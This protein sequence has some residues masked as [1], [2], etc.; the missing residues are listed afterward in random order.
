MNDE[1]RNHI[2]PITGMGNDWTVF[3]YFMEQRFESSIAEEYVLPVSIV[4][5]VYNR[6]EK[7]AKTIAA[8][9]HQTYPN[10]LMEIIIADDGSSDNPQELCETFKSFFKMSYIYQEDRGYRLSEIRNKGV[11]AAIH[12]Q[13]IILDCDMLPL[14]NLVESYMKYA[15]IS[16]KAVLIGGRR[17]VNTDNVSWEEIIDD[18]TSVSTLPSLDSGTGKIPEKGKPPSEDWRYKIYRSTNQL[19]NSKYPF[20]AFCG[21][22][23]CFHKSLI[24]DVGGFDEDFTA[25]GAEDTE[26]GFRVY[27]QG[28]W[29]IPV[30]GAEALHQEP[31]EGSNETDRDAG[32]AITQPLLIEKCPAFYR[33]MEKDRIYEVPKVSIYIPAYN[34][35]KFIVEAINSALNQTYTDIEIVVVNDGSIDSTGELLDSIYSSNRR[36]R[37]IHQKNGGISSATNTAINAC[38]GEY[39]LQLDSDDAIL[40]ETVELLVAVLDR[41]DIGFVYGDSYLIDSE[42]N[43]IGR[44]YSWSM[45][46]RYK[47]L[48]GMMIHHPRMFRKRDFNRTRQFNNDLSNAVDYD[49]FLKMSEITDGFHLQTPLYLYRQHNTNT[50]IVNTDTQDNNNHTCIRNAFSRLGL[51]DMV[52]LIP[53]PNHKRKMIA[54]IKPHPSKY[55]LD[56]TYNLTQKGIITSKGYYLWEINNMVSTESME[57]QERRA[58]SPLRIVRVGSYGSIKVANAVLIKIE[59]EYGVEGIIFSVP[60]K[61]GRSYFIDLA[62]PNNDQKSLELMRVLSR[63]H[64][65]KTEVIC[66]QG[67]RDV[68][69]V[70]RDTSE[71]FELYKKEMLESNIAVEKGQH[72][73]KYHIPNFW[74]LQGSK[75]IFHWREHKIFFQMPKDWSLKNTHED[76]LRL[77]HYVMVSPWDTSVLDGW[78][79]SRKPGWRPGLAFSGGV[80]SAAALALMPSS[81]V[82]VYNERSGIKGILDHTNAF[83]FFEHLKTSHNR[84]VIRIKSNHESI[85]T[86]D[87]KM[88][89]FSTDYACAVQVI[90]LADYYGFDSIGTGMP[91]EN[92]YLWHGYKFRDFSDTWFWKHYSKLFSDVGLDL[93]QPVAGCSEIINMEIVKQIQWDGWAQ[94]CLRSK[95]EGD[96]CGKCWKCFRK[97]ALLGVP[98]EYAG[99]IKNFL[100][101]RPLKQA[102]STIYSIQKGGVSKEGVVIKDEIEDIKHLLNDNYQWMDNHYPP[103]LNLLPPRYLNYTKSK[104]EKYARP[105][106][107]EDISNLEGVN[108][109]PE[110]KEMMSNE[111]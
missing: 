21:G 4:I 102:A 2:P 32:K 35:E 63:K 73:A 84:E 46:D 55:T 47:L 19:K 30:D 42:G 83:R 80:D 37:I 44:A 86:Q 17:Y 79:P 48:D 12:E 105:M 103:A 38:R 51:S 36:V 13:I 60:V 96:V 94:S 98:F 53:D 67:E 7:L 88:A 90:L 76:L 85:R 10:E 74:S 82:L 20:R 40:P 64:N 54:S 95:V 26:F 27:N 15:H 75:L 14:P 93:Y 87:G 9:T 110:K 106:S 52:S 49:F 89:G 107:A 100:Q 3:Q 71:S 81:T 50:S 97:N 78:K 18:I 24:Q 43:N 39:I 16:N 57:R 108:M 45:Y 33:R 92:S 59:K 66:R 41:N 31:P 69:V 101:K 8:L 109:F 25:W 68:I 70:N 58:I 91:L 65:W 5:P 111:I 56:L 22:N 104:L 61:S 77:A 11:D 34:A 72:S 23:V 28:Y 62:A 99:E 1:V 29:F 6:K